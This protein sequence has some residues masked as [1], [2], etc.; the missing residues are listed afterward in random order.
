MAKDYDRT[1]EEEPKT[2]V[3][4]EDPNDITEEPEPTKEEL[5]KLKAEN[6]RLKMEKVEAAA[7]ARK[8]KDLQSRSERELGLVASSVILDPGSSKL[9]MVQ[10]THVNKKG[11]NGEDVTFF[12]HPI[13]AVELIAQGEAFLTKVGNVET[14]NT[15]N[16]EQIMK[17]DNAELASL[18]SDLNI[19]LDLTAFSKVEERRIA[20]IA[21]L[22]NRK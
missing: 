2:D 9:G 14:Q 3:T 4:P 5:K 19:K 17:M 12:S 22:A 15:V 16:P 18:V 8:R 13:D 20:V 10:M 6:Q 21:I 7:K 1:K 11:A